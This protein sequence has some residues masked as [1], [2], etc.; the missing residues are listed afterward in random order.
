M[1]FTIS[2]VSPKTRTTEILMVCLFVCKRFIEK[3]LIFFKFKDSFHV[4]SST[5]KGLMSSAY[6]AV[7]SSTMDYQGNFN[8][9]GGCLIVGPGNVVHYFHA[10]KHA[11]DHLPINFILNKVGIKSI[12]FKNAPNQSNDSNKVHKV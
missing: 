3:E 11:R 6:R 8:Q 7:R 1:T 10:D 4:K 2:L 5:F 9:Q 12:D